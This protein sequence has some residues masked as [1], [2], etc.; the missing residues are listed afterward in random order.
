M[1]RRAVVEPTVGLAA[2]LARFDDRVVD[3]GVRAAAAAGSTLARVTQVRVEVSVEA[4]VGAITR[5]VGA[6]GRLARQP[7]T[8][9]L[10]HYYAQAVVVLAALVILLMIAR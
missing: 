8:G 6:L 1:V 9:Q 2:A 7:Q 10:H 5:S 3:G 4:V